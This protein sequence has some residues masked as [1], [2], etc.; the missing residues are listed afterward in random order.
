VLDENNCLRTLLLDRLNIGDE[1]LE[2][3]L[4][5]TTQS[6]R[7]Q[8]DDVNRVL[9]LSAQSEIGSLKSLMEDSAAQLAALKRAMKRA[10][11]SAGGGGDGEEGGGGVGG[12]EE[13]DGD[14]APMAAV[15]DE[16]AARELAAVKE[17]LACAAAGGQKVRTATRERERGAGMM[18][19]ETSGAERRSTGGRTH[20]YASPF[21]REGR[22]L[23]WAGGTTPSREPHAW[24][25]TSCHKAAPL[26][27]SFSHTHT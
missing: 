25:A 16:D 15:V 6:V 14:E 9:L 1:E 13:Q 12:E 24:D 10:A 19:K 2:N 23:R 17:Q 26:S 11:A 27:L 22:C 3:A 7:Q 20:L 5:A 8:N 21:P 4:G 18:G